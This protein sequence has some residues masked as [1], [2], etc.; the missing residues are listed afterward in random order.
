MLRRVYVTH[1]A[2]KLAV[3]FGRPSRHKGSEVTNGTQQVKARQTC[4]I[5]Y[6]HEHL[7]GSRLKQ[8]GGNMKIAVRRRPF[9][10]S[11][12]FTH[13]RGPWPTVGGGAFGEFVFVGV[14][15]VLAPGA[16]NPIATHLGGSGRRISRVVGQE[17]CRGVAKLVARASQLKVSVHTRREE[18]LHVVDHN[19]NTAMRELKITHFVATAKVDT[20]GCRRIDPQPR[21]YKGPA[22]LEMVFGPASLKSST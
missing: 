12:G 5:K 11:L 20:K 6:C 17:R 4:S 2:M 9:L 7:G 1:K 21:G 8:S 22:L 18:V 14:K 16:S 10:S 15:G 13:G 3:T 19:P